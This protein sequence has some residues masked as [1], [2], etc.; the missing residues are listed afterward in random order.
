MHDSRVT[1]KGGKQSNAVGNNKSNHAQGVLDGMSI[2]L[3]SICVDIR[4]DKKVS[5]ALLVSGAVG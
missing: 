1:R 5:F 2:S 3:Y 4:N